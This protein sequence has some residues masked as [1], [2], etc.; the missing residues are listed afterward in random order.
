MS[1]L[2][3]QRLSPIQRWMS[4]PQAWDIWVGDQ[5]PAEFMDGHASP[6]EAVDAYAL[7]SPLF[8]ELHPEDVTHVRG[9]LLAVLVESMEHSSRQSWTI[10]RDDAERA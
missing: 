8:D 7:G 3:F 5:T 1:E 6:E 2:R 9:L 10:V 4:S